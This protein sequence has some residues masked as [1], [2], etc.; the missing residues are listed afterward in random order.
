[1]I[2]TFIFLIACVGIYFNFKPS[3]KMKQNDVFLEYNKYGRYSKERTEK[4]IK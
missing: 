2:L 1:M 3:L 4:R